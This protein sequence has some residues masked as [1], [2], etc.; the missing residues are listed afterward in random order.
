MLKKI[1]FRGIDVEP[2]LFDKGVNIIFGDKAEGFQT[3]NSVGKSLLIAVIDHLLGAQRSDIFDFSELENVSAV[4]TFEFSGLEVIIE[5]FLDPKNKIEVS[6]VNIIKNESKKLNKGDIGNITVNKWLSYLQDVY[7]EDEFMSFRS[8]NRMF[9][10]DSEIE[11]FKQAIKSFSTDTNWERGRFNSYFLDLGHEIISSNKQYT[12]R[13]K[14]VLRSIAP[15]LHKVIEHD[16]SAIGEV[17]ERYT[18]ISLAL[19]KLYDESRLKKSQIRILENNLNE[20]ESVSSTDFKQKFQIYEYEL[21]SLIIENYESTKKFHDDLIMDNKSLIISELESVKKSLINNTEKITELLVER[22]IL[23]KEI[24]SFEEQDVYV[25]ATKELLAKFLENQDINELVKEA[26][27]VSTD[28]TTEKISEYL[29]SKID[30]IA[31]Y[32]EFLLKNVTKLYPDIDEIDFNIY[33]NDSGVFDIDFEY[34]GTQGEGKGTIRTLLYLFLLIN[35]NKG[36][37]L[38][39]LVLDSNV[40]DSVDVDVLNSL[41]LILDNYGKQNNVQIICAGNRQNFIQNVKL[42]LSIV[43][44]PDKPLFKTHLTT[45]KNNNK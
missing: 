29:S 9:L 35:I 15:T 33:V 25:N 21:Q 3:N 8:F 18:S 34:E 39:Y 43:L 30:R 38:D 17:Q 40:I 23:E 41:L 32:R 16:N 10:R 22:G 27:R 1:E 20:V 24:K 4:G 13:E 14:A 44:T 28:V 36:G 37:N 19:R 26:D 5:R 31:E 2:I 11:K 45:R 6:N 7:V 42:K 12:I